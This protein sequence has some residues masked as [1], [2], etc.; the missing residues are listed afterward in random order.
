MGSQKLARL[1]VFKSHRLHLR[2]NVM[3]QS[4]PVHVWIPSLSGDHRSTYQGG[5]E[6]EKKKKCCEGPARAHVSNL[7]RVQRLRGS[8][9]QPRAHHT[10]GAHPIP[11]REAG[12]PA[13]TPR[14]PRGAVTEGGVGWEALPRSYLGAPGNRGHLRPAARGERGRASPGRRRR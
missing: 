7:T 8:P 6:W 9:P 4:K 10:A 1:P 12:A 5:Q 14:L 3:I 2:I 11:W 13:W